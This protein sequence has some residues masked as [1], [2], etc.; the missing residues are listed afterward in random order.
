MK[1]KHLLIAFII[2][3]GVLS[4]IFVGKDLIHD[5]KNKQ[6]Y[7]NDSEQAP[8]E[9]SNN[10]N[11]E[12]ESIYDLDKE[13]DKA[14][15]EN[16][17]MEEDIIIEKGFKTTISNGS[18]EKEIKRNNNLLD[19]SKLPLKERIKAKNAAE[20]FVQAIESFDIEKPKETVDLAVK[21][22]ADELKP[23]VEALYMYLGKN[24]D[25]KKKVIEEVQSYEKENE[26]GNDYILFD[27]YV[28]WN[29]VDQYDQVANSGR[30]SYEVKLLKIDDKY[31][32]V[33]YR[34]I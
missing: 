7:T 14:D 31:K 16:N 26:Y 2:L 20:N 27:V 1:K 34:V 3:V 24:Q 29:V 13:L 30:S 6:E 10:F 28:K 21:Y 5:I 32:V 11:N 17:F 4:I 23:E 18:S 25:I 12:S 19:G 8:N 15:K 9:N 22:A 33:S